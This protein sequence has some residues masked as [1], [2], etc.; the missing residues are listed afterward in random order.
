MT[1]N[2][3]AFSPYEPA[4]DGFGTKSNVWQTIQLLADANEIVG[5]EVP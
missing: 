4:A 2:N 5:P 1:C 3:D